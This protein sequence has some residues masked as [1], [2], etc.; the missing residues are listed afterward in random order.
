MLASTKV[1]I[2]KMGICLKAQIMF[3]KD[4]TNAFAS[5][6]PVAELFKIHKN[7]LASLNVLSGECNDV[8]KKFIA[9]RN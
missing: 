5:G 7:F 1:V 9:N 4:V 2:C 8:T 6:L 3:N